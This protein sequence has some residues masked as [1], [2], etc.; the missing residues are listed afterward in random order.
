M[1]TV[2]LSASLATGK[3]GRSDWANKTA[4]HQG[5]YST[6]GYSYVGV[7][8]FP[9]LG[10]TLKDT[11]I[12]SISMTF[13]IAGGSGAASRSL[14]F[15]KSNYQA[16]D[17]SIASKNYVGDPLGALS[18]NS[19]TGTK[20]YDM[21]AQTNGEMFAALAAYLEA[22]NECL[23]LYN[24][25]T[26][27]YSSYNFSRNYLKITACTITVEY[28]DDVSRPVP[29]T[30]AV[31]LGAALVISMEKKL[32]NATHVLSYTFGEASGE[33]AG[34][35]A[36]EAMW[37]PG[38]DLAFQIPNAVSGVAVIT[39]ETWADG[40]LVGTAQTAVTLTVPDWMTP[41]ADVILT[42]T[43]GAK[44]IFGVYAQ[45]VSAVSVRMVGSG[46]YG[47]EVV[48]Q[49]AVYGGV[50][51]T[52][53]FSTGILADT[54]E[55]TLEVTVTDSRGRT[56]VQI[57][58]VQA[59]AYAPPSLSLNASRCLEDGTA[60]DVGEFALV[61]ISGQVAD[62]DATNTARLQL[63]YGTTTVELDCT[64]GN[65]TTTTIVPAPSVSSMAIAAVLSDAL[66][67][68]TRSMVLSIGYVTVDFLAGGK[69]ITFG[70]TAT[71]PGFTCAMDTD[72]AGH[73][74]TGL[75][76]PETEDAAATKGYVDAAV[77]SSGCVSLEVTGGTAFPF[78]MEE[79]ELYQLSYISSSLTAADVTLKVNAA[80][81]GNSLSSYSAVNSTT[82]YGGGQ[83]TRTGTSTYAVF[84]GF[85]R[86]MNG[87][88]LVWGTDLRGNGVAGMCA[89]VWKDI[90]AV[91]SLTISAAGTVCYQ[92]L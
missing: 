1:A 30:D 82:S 37:I 38:E 51:Y 26:G 35:V 4:A 27:T 22:G 55:H 65:F 43:S 24:G 20:S 79:G 11:R 13:T 77:K 89:H 84:N 46:C 18:G 81:A 75:P 48:S 7:L 25:E 12:D 44:E 58:T 50:T 63:T 69:G 73:P 41:E 32:E 57:W 87:R 28:D 5:N 34:D 59:A 80:A 90:Q 60:D 2:Q 49:T 29:S 86:L 54:K 19:G 3:Y 53:D 31:E 68:A 92:K 21:D 83:I 64:T 17:T 42:D 14:S 52:S 61:T 78:A 6:N 76:T 10:E 71:K 74:L 62:M 16:L 33:I 56:A 66:F 39:C 91:E 88:L 36:D 67:S 45:G 72:L 9:G 47:S 85:L 8:V 40:A 15:C 23:V 70:T